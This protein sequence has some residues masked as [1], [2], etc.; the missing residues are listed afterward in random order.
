[1]LIIPIRG[2]FEVTT[3]DGAVRQFKAGDVLVAEDTW[4]DGHRTRIIGDI[5]LITLFVELAD[6]PK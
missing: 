1:M 3:S 6:T 5:D 4:G 2:A